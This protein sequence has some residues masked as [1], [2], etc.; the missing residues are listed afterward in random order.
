MERARD[1]RHSRRHCPS[2]SLMTPRATQSWKDPVRILWT[3]LALRNYMWQLFNV[4][5]NLRFRVVDSELWKSIALRNDSTYVLHLT[6]SSPSNFLQPTQLSQTW[7]CE[8]VCIDQCD[9]QEQG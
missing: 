6:T 1:L 7:V 8:R 5:G 4:V 3:L 9:H 2:L